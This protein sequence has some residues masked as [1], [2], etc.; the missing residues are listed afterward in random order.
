[1][2]PTIEPVASFTWTLNNPNNNK[3]PNEDSQDLQ[4]DDSNLFEPNRFAG[5]DEVEGGARITYGMRF[6]AFGDSGELV[7]G[8]FGQSYRISGEHDEFD[9]ST[10]IDQSLS[11]YWGRI[12]LT[13]DESFRVRYRFRIDQ[14]S[15]T[16]TQNEVGA[17][18]GPRRAPLQRRLHLARKRPGAGRK[19][20]PRGGHRRRVARP[21]A[22][23]LAARRDPAQP[24]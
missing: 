7:S 20:E 18:F 1:M 11:D 14:Q 19:P 15:L 17:V 23:A 21:V 6:G 3:I 4:I 16:P 5:L 9:P 12:D 2:T 8:L 13:P 10:G 24:G 22:F